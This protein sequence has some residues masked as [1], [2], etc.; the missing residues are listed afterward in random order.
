MSGTLSAEGPLPDPTPSTGP[1]PYG[2][3]DAEPAWMAIDWRSQMRT[4]SLDGTEVEIVEAGPRDSD[5]E[6]LLLVHGL[7]GS[8][9]N[10][11]ETIPHF[12]E[13]RRVV[14]L[15]LPGFGSSR[16]PDWEISIPRYAALLAQL[17]DALDL[18]PSCLVGSSMGGLIA[19]ET[20][21]SHPAAVSRLLL[22]APVGISNATLELKPAIRF[23]RTLSLLAPLGLRLRSASLIRP[24]LLSAAFGGV[25]HHPRELRPEL[26]WEHYFGALATGGKATTPGFMAAVK[27]VVGYDIREQ[28]AEISAPAL[29]VWGRDDKLVPPQDGPEYARRIVGA[30]LEVFGNCGHLPMLERPVRFNQVLAEFLADATS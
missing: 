18:G 24:R 28:L 5:R 23:A 15:D 25:L 6:P 1:D 11:L 17:H 8:W 3:P 27:A 20:A 7:D 4:L 14:A 29:V 10:F 21:I 2:N 12:A 13:S 26:L 22:A 9:R 16:L 30:R 19:A